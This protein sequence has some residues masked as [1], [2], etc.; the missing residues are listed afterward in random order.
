MTLVSP[1]AKEVAILKDGIA[2]NLASE[3]EI[4]IVSCAI[5]MKSI[6]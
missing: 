3:A 4:K 2:F 6:G 1:S 5:Q